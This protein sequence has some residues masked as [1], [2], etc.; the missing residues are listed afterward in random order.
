MEC[1]RVGINLLWLV[2]GD[3]GGSED[4]A[5]GLVRELSEVEEL[6]LVVFCQAALPAAHPD[7]AASTELVVG[8]SRGNVRCLRLLWEASWLPRQVRHHRL[9]LVHHLGGTVPPLGRRAVPAVLSVYDL[10]PLVH[11]E[12]FGPAKRVWLRAVL[13]R[14]AHRAD[15]V[16]TLTEHVRTQVIERLGAAAAR[17]RVAS[18]GVR[19][20]HHEG[21]EAAEVVRRTYGLDGDLLLYPA[22]SYL[23]KNHDVLLEALPA[24]LD[25]HPGTTLVLTGRPGPQ[26]EH[27]DA[28]ARQLGIADSVRRLGRIPRDHLDALFT[29]A[30]VLVFPSTYEGFG[31]P[32]LEAMVHGLPIVASRASAIP[33]VVQ[34][35]G[36]LVDPHDATAWAAA[37]DRVLAD[38]GERSALSA[39]ASEG[40]TR[41]G[42]DRTTSVVADLYRQLAAGSPL[43]VVPGDATSDRQVS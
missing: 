40:A 25:R 41:F 38:P 1:M 13:P 15:A 11:P 22:I 29:A 17:V 8:P 35:S 3:V 42:W 39:A 21:H 30:A 33:E 43:D 37:V 28:R 31:L 4:Y 7:L 14:S 18:P 19:R 6:D 5:V 27:L 16:L 2:P 26:D 20:G 9:D 10:Q 34:G 36:V 24:V 12:R 32:L 23:H